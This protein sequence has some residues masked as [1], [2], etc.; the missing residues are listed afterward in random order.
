MKNRNLSDFLPAIHT[1][2]AMTLVD[3]V[4]E[5]RALLAA[6]VLSD[7]DECVGIQ[8]QNPDNQLVDVVVSNARLFRQ[9]AALMTAYI[10]DGFFAEQLEALL[11]TARGS[12]VAG[13]RLMPVFCTALNRSEELEL[14]ISLERKIMTQIE[15]Q[16]QRDGFAVTE[17]SSKGASIVPA[18][19]VSAAG[20]PTS[21]DII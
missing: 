17:L 10:K 3:V 1:I 19:G 16:R 8:R 15:R 11:R 6:L 18:N 2:L 5:C 7:P 12:R 13:A 9:D 14:P 20:F 21:H 4:D